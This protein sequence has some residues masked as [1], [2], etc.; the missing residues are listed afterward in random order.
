MPPLTAVSPLLTWI[1]VM[2]FLV[3][4]EG[5][6]AAAQLNKLPVGALRVPPTH[7]DAVVRRDL[8]GHFEP[9]D[10]LL[11]RDRCGALALPGVTYGISVPCSIALLV[12]A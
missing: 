5:T 6:E 10:G 2:T 3:S 1:C 11:E 8:W 12:I 9:E 7:D 4:I